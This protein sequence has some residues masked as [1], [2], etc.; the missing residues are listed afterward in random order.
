MPRIAG[1]R[2][3]MDKRADLIS[4]RYGSSLVRVTCGKAQVLF[5][6]GQVVF[7]RV[8]RFSPTFDERLARYKWNILEM[9]V[10]PK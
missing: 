5:M 6:D 7:P 8:L 10:K 4:H 2:S 9:A 3:L 1:C